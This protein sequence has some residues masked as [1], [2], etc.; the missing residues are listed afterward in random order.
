MDDIRL[1][2]TDRAGICCAAPTTTR[3]VI[4]THPQ[5]PFQTRLSGGLP[6]F[7][8]HPTYAPVVRVSVRAWWFRLAPGFSCCMDLVRDPRT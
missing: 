5:L 4:N 1:M 2:A 6:P 3:T 7:S 8:R